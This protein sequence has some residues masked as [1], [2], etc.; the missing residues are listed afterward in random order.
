MCLPIQSNS[1]IFMSVEKL[2]T[3]VLKAAMEIEFTYL[4]ASLY[5]EAS[6]KLGEPKALSQTLQIV[7][8]SHS[9]SC[10]DR[11]A[12]W[13]TCSIFLL[14]SCGNRGDIRRWHQ[15]AS[16]L[17]VLDSCCG[18]QVWSQTKFNQKTEEVKLSWNPSHHASPSWSGLSLGGL[19]PCSWAD[20]ESRGVLMV[21]ILTVTAGTFNF[22]ERS[23]GQ[24]ERLRVWERHVLVLYTERGPCV[25]W[26]YIETLI[27]TAVSSAEVFMFMWHQTDCRYKQ[28]LGKAVRISLRVG[29]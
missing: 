24:R 7:G 28:P 25:C 16:E 9:Y 5:L 21:S 12:V 4:L 15:L 14:K 26:L 1:C 3:V 22:P 11:W 29:V 6:S 20:W 13:F 19:L 23:S 18:S 10:A 17:S 2:V 8:F 27:W